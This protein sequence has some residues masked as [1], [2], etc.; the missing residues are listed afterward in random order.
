MSRGDVHVSKGYG[1]FSQY[2]CFLEL[3]GRLYHLVARSMQAIHKVL[4]IPAPQP[5]GRRP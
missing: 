2:A 1:R 4:Q 5:W 3:L